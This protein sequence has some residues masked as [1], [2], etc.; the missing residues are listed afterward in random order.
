MSVNF[1]KYIHCGSHW[2]K[3][4]FAMYWN[5][6][7]EHT[8]GAVGKESGASFFISQYGSRIL[9]DLNTCVIWDVSELHGTGKYEE[10]LKHVGIAVLSKATV[11]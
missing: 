1:M 10:G 11:E 4:P 6:L 3:C 2:G 7:W 5:L 9:N 8:H